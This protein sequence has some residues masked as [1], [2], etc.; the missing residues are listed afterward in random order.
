MA[1]QG[2]EGILS[3]FLVN[4]RI[5]AAKFFLRGKILDFGCGSGSLTKFVS[6]KD[7]FGY[8]IDEES[9]VFA[10]MQYP[11]FHFQTSPNIPISTFDTVVCLAVIEHLASPKEL[12][13]TLASYLKPSFESRI[14]ITTPNPSF[15]I[16]HHIGAKFGIF[17]RQ[18][19]EEHQSFLDKKRIFALANETNLDIVKY[20][21]FLYG[22][23]QLVVL[24]V[25]KEDK[26]PKLS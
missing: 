22:A 9:I 26:S 13:I 24:R 25:N 15:E 16:I 10:R 12:L 11:K 1:N 23:N 20:K 2:R 7:Y 21:K 5:N 19:D 6:Y 14:I 3:S 18:A 4:K 8:D 17:S